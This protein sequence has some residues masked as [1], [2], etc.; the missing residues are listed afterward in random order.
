AR[1]RY[2][3]A[4]ASPLG[5]IDFER[6]AIGGMS[7]GGMCALRRLCDPAP[8]PF[9]CAAVESTT[10]WLGGLYFGTD[11]AAGPRWAVRHDPAEVAAV[12]PMERIDAFRPIP[13]L[14]L[15][16]EQDRTVP[17][18]GQRRFLEALRERYEREGADPEL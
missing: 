13:L 5:A 17:I 15:H 10:G 3:P 16:S 8:H 2:G 12:D 9:R 11:G 1:D 14:A 18:A 7:A 4:A 6:L